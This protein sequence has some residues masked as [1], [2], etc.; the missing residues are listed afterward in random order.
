MSTLAVNRGALDEAV[1]RYPVV[2]SLDVS[3]EF[4]HGMKIAVVRRRPVAA[5]VG[6]GAP[7]A[8][9]SD[10]VLLRGERTTGLAAVNARP[11]IG[12]ERL[13]GGRALE[14]VRILAAAPAH[15]RGRVSSVGYA[16]GGYT[17]RVAG[18]PELRF[19]APER[20][21]SKWAAAA[22]I[23][24]DPSVAS[25]SYVDLRVPERPAVGPPGGS[26]EGFIP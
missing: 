7:V 21:E 22:R 13:T 18:Y 10:G 8:V 2:K 25:A 16:G 12:A 6:G 11:P 15:L 5:L 24:R 20:L 26:E 23:L 9:A 1:A 17:A 3:T 14:Q 19:G 4:P